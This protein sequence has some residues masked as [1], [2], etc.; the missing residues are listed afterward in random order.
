MSQ[1]KPSLE[2]VFGLLSDRMQSYFER[3]KR[4]VGRPDEKG[5]PREEVVLN[6]LKEFL[7]KN[8][9]IAKG[10]VINLSGGC[11]KECDI[12]LFRESS[13]L[14]KISPTNELYLIPIED[15]YGVIEVKSILDKK[16]YKNCQEKQE[17]VLEIHKNR[18]VD[19]EEHIHLGKPLKPDFAYDEPFF[20]VF[21]YDIKDSDFNDNFY[22]HLCDSPFSY[23]FCLNRGVYSN[24][25]DNTIIRHNSL[26]LGITGNTSSHNSSSLNEIVSR[27]CMVDYHSR[28]YDDFK[29]DLAQN[30]GM[31][32]VMFAYLADRLEDSE[33]ENYSIAD[34]ISLWRKSGRQIG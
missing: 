23:I 5:F 32:M 14:F 21:C 13:P 18:W 12:I 31:L 16:Q 24:V 3:T 30:G 33:L 34:Y 10:Y 6:F 17:S 27:D 22:I 4:L 25:T 29:V 11:S 7:P 28:C 1:W 26:N 19:E 20:S 2:D 9:G 8:I 15:V